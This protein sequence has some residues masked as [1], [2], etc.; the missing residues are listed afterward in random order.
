VVVG[1]LVATVH[2]VIGHDL[3]RVRV[4]CPRQI[5]CKVYVR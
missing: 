5:L 3:L 4:M 2:Q 1:Y